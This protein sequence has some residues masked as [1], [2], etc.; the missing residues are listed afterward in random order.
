VAVVGAGQQMAGVAVITY[1]SSPGGHLQA[2]YLRDM[3]V[4]LSYAQHTRRFLDDYLSSFRRVLIDS[5]AFSVLNSGKQ[6]DVDAYAEWSAEYRDLPHVD[7][8]AALDDIAGDWEQ[9]LANWRRHPWMFPTYHDSDPQEALD[10]IL[11]YSPQWLGLGMVPPRDSE[12]WLLRTLGRIPAEVHIHGWALR[13]FTWH[14][15]LDSVDSTNWMLDAWQM[16]KTLPW[17]TP[18]ECIE[19]IVKRY[20]RE[21]RT[22]RQ[23]AIQQELDLC[24]VL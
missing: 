24:E 14:P 5:G 13:A 16:K 23:P 21:R 15:R 9:G 18:A 20:Q 22:K 10:A 7:A 19:I 11:A 2:D 17:L 6:I 3:P 8:V 1:L 12:A 4:L